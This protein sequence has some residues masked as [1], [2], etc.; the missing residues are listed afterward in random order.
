MGLED[1]Q[2]LQHM[3]VSLKEHKD[4]VT[5]ITINADGTEFATSSHDGSCLVWDMK[6]YHR[7][8]ALFNNTKFNC[9]QYHPDGSQLVTTGFDRKITNWCAVEATAIRVVDGSENGSVNHLAMSP[10]GNH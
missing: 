8:N 5:S 3:E 10:S 7:V 1:R 9:I 4:K 6:K 2:Q